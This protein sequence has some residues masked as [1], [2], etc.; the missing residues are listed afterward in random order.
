MSRGP[1]PTS[2]SRSAPL[3]WRGAFLVL[4]VVSLLTGP[5]FAGVFVE[6]TMEGE[7]TE[8]GEGLVLL[9]YRS[10]TSLMIS[11]TA[12]WNDGT[13]TDTA[14]ATD[15]SLRLEQRGDVPA[16]ATPTWRDS[17][18]ALRYCVAV[19]NAGV[20]I[21]EH[22]IQLDLDTASLI[23]DGDLLADAADLRA[24]DSATGAL[25][26]L[27]VEGPVP[28]SASS[29]WVQLA[30]APSGLSEFCLYLA[31]PTATTVS[32]EQAVFTYTTPK[33]RY[34]TGNDAWTGQTL[35]LVSY[36]DNNAVVVDGGAPVVMNRGQVQTFAVDRD[37]VIEASGPVSGG[38]A[39]DGTDSII[40]ESYAATSFVF[41]INRNPQ[42]VY[43]R[44]P[45]ASTTIEFVV[46]GV[47]IATNQI[48]VGGPGVLSHTVAPG[49]GAVGFTADAA[50]AQ[51][52]MV[53]S[54]N[55]VPFIAS[56][57]TNI[58]T[59]GLIGVPWTGE[60]LY[61]IKSVDLLVG[62]GPTTVNY[63]ALGS[64]GTVHTGTV[65]PTALASYAGGMARGAG[66]AYAI[67]GSSQFAASQFADSNGNEAT[68][69]YPTG[70]LEKEYYLPLASNYV[71]IACPTPGQTVTIT[72]PLGIPVPLICLNPGGLAGAPGHAYIGLT[73]AGFAAGT[74]VSS[75]A[76]FYAIAERN[77][78][79]DE[80]NLVGSKA[81]RPSS[82]LDP[83]ITL[84]P[85]Q[86]VH[87]LSGTWNSPV[88]DTGAAGIYG[89][90]SILATV[91]SGTSF[92]VQMATGGTAGDAATATLVGPDGTSSTSY[93]AGDVVVP[94]VHD[95]QPFVRFEVTLATT[96][97]LVSPSVSSIDLVTELSEFVT[98]SDALTTIDVSADPGV[99]S[100]LLAR[101][102]GTGTL[103]Y[104][105]RIRY[106][107]G[108][109]LPAAN[110]ITV[111]TDHPADHVQAVAGAIVQGQGA[112]FAIAPGASFSLLIDE[113]IA[114][115]NV[116]TIDVTL[117]AEA[118]GGALIEHDLRFVL[119]AP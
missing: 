41:A 73:V 24:I 61:G 38:S 78:G 4:F 96:D 99:D 51:A 22:P 102:H 71:S 110:L 7:T 27:W 92:R 112:A 54:T 90:L 84:G 76:P 72:T 50:T 31:N 35:S 83:S 94:P 91:P 116:V 2:S 85:L 20:G 88:Y 56:H 37:S 17:D 97:P 6:N 118:A 67:T 79:D 109:G 111:R 48:G 36:V 13:F 75:T 29:I 57:H 55:G 69:F 117:T 74:L 47:V 63:S 53:R 70:L 26:P 46:N 100:H 10:G 12:D 113:D 21:T 64:D 39:G 14:T 25:L 81:A 105:A 93:G 119:T 3:G 95:N 19:N 106:R 23:A 65:G 11:G 1:Q 5:A 34:Y 32:D 58:T 43:V 59:D 89:L 28:S 80:I 49:D 9:D 42:Q 108:T 40:P 62:G 8:I 101:I 103:A 68:N 87:A 33:V 86:G 115:G 60:T 30:S 45:F 98:S 44:A 104:T 52:V 15:G 77:S 18:W 66:P 16:S 82:W 107:G 114:S